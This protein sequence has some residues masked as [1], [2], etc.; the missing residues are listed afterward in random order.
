MKKIL[1]LV[2]VL[3]Y[4]VLFSQEIER[5]CYQDIYTQ[6]LYNSLTKSE[7]RDLELKKLQLDSLSV[8]YETQTQTRNVEGLEIGVDYI[9]PTVVHIIDNGDGLRAGAI[10]YQE[11]E[12]AIEMLNHF[13]SGK[14][15]YD[16]L[17]DPEFIPVRGAFSNKKIKFVL[18]NYDPNGNSTT[19]VEFI[20]DNFYATRGQL[21]GMRQTYHWPRENYFNIYVVD[22][23][24]D[25]SYS[26]FATFPFA[27]DSSPELDGHVMQYWAF[28]EQ[29][30]CWE[31][32]Y[33][34]LSH[35]VGHWI[36][37]YH[38]WS[39]LNQSCAYD[40]DVTDTPNTDGNSYSDFDDFP[41][42]G[43]ITTCGSKDNITNMMDYT[44]AFYAMFTNGQRARMEAS[45][46]SS[47]AERNNLW[48]T[49]NVLSKIYGCTTGTDTDGDQIPDA[50]DDCPNDYYNDSDGD[51]ICDSQDT[52]NGK[53]DVDLDSFEGISDACDPDYPIIDFITYP[54]NS[55]PGNGDAGVSDVYDSGCTA[56]ISNNGWKKVDYNYTVTTQTV[57]EFDFKSTIEGEIHAIGFDTDG[58]GNAVLFYPLFGRQN[59]N[60][61]APPIVNN[62][63]KDYSNLNT[64]KHYSIPI[65]QDYT[66]A[67]SNIIFIADSDVRD[68][69]L[70][71]YND[72]TSFFRNVKIY[73]K[74]CQLITR[75][76]GS[77]DNGSPDTTKAVVID[78]NYNTSSGG[79]IEACTLTIL[80]GK[81]LTIDASDYVK[82]EGRIINNGTLI[83]EHEGSVVQVDPDA[84][85][86]NNGTI[87]VNL[88][89]PNLATRDFMVLGSPMTAETRTDVWNSAFLVLN[90]DT[91]KFVPNPDV[92]AAF[93]LAE[94]FAD[95]NY[96]NWSEY[97]G[98]INVGEGYIVRPQAGYGEPGGIFNYTYNQGTLNNGD[99][100]FNIVYNTPGPLPADNQNASP[101]ILANP[102]PSAIWANDFINAN[103]S[104]IDALY[105]WEHNTPPNPSLP[106]AGSMNFSMEDISMYNLGGGVSAASGGNVPN[107]YIATGQGFAVKAL[108]AGTATFTNAMRRTDNNNT[109]R[110]TS[111][112]SVERIW[113]KVENPKFEM[114]SS[115]LIVFSENG[116]SAIDAGYDSKRLATVVSLYSQLEDGGGEFGIQTLEPL[117]TEAK[118]PIGFSTLIEEDVT[119]KISLANFEGKTIDHSSIILYDAVDNRMVNL[120]TGPYSFVAGKGT[121]NNRFFLIIKQQS[122]ILDTA[123]NDFENSV[124]VFPNPTNGQLAIISPFAAIEGVVVYDLQG[125]VVAIKN[126]TGASVTMDISNM[127]SSVYFMKIATQGGAITKRIVKQ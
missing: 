9:I 19:G 114:Q 78:A 103:S 54:I 85:V 24:S 73:E 112:E 116:T 119:Y 104:M 25:G 23:F 89:T 46:N 87:N 35:E 91:T 115:T 99:V 55:F 118:I 61:T 75:F 6:N 41:G 52:C 57:L 31:T 27:V 36:N 125:R 113:L 62:A 16:E 53:P 94:N 21:D 123:Q 47:I 3:F 22:A 126:E 39:Y 122:R 45:L 102:Y 110:V 88:T 72:G 77:W 58:T 106:G 108:S 50:C 8:T 101:N 67:I 56:Y 63:F 68:N 15:A 20:N 96:D 42:V 74:Q 59:W 117:N 1:F 107:G 64:W 66:G 37:L 48:T 65:G 14:S 28:G 97:N 32:W 29:D 12:R 124:S 121:I 26:G 92:A 86:T 90:H 11:V 71:Y 13:F 4:A 49:T 17:I 82:L 44:S 69:T 60:P 18:A 5:T 30:A 81:T 38:I 95:D 33:H 40:D 120:K 100:T 127:Q 76:S 70:G 98:G 51:G 2:L 83:V 109:L 105:F 93:P 10:D 43:A 34:N 84:E 79:S 111:D 80:S 7:I